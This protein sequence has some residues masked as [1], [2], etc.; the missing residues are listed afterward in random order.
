MS[1]A[2]PATLGPVVDTTGPQIPLVRLARVEVRKLVDTRAGFWLVT[3]IGVIATVVMLVLLIASRNTPEELTFGYFFGMM[4]V[5]TA[6]ILP[7]LAILL[8][9][10]EWSQ[11]TALTTFTIEPRRGRVVLA[12]LVAVLV[13]AVGAFCLALALGAVGT[14]IAGAT[15]GGG[16]GAWEISAA[17]LVNNAIVLIFELLLGFGFAALIMNTPG[18][19]VAFFALPTAMSLVTELVPWYRDNMGD[20]V[21]TSSTNAAFQSAEWATGGDWARML[22]SGLVWIAIP[23]TVGV[24]RIVRS[25]VK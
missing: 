12:K 10:G 13:A 11:R 24:A 21:D 8:V 18:A 5:P 9:T 16:A 15:Y 1:I 19:I 2:A 22:F 23:L 17:G 3:S 6:I 25:E 7:V 20:W 4:T 14:L